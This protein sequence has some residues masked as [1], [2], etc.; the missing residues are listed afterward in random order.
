MIPSVIQLIQRPEPLPSLVPD[1]YL[2]RDI[3][4]LYIQHTLKGGN[5][6]FRMNRF[7]FIVNLFLFYCPLGAICHQFLSRCCLQTSSFL[8]VESI[9]VFFSL[10]LKRVEVYIVVCNSDS[11]LE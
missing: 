6:A 9:L 7:G 10:F 4:H 3:I 1:F 11:I 8:S 2:Q 5:R